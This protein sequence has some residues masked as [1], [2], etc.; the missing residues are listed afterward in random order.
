MM[1][2][3]VDEQGKV[4]V[5]RIVVLGCPEELLSRGSGTVVKRGQEGIYFVF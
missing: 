2:G 1:V 3:W 5:I 4:V